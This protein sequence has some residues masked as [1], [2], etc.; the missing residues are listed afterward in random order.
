MLMCDWS[1]YVCS[2]DLLAD[3]S[4]YTPDKVRIF[5][6]QSEIHFRGWED[7]GARRIAELSNEIGPQC[8]VVVGTLEPDIRINTTDM[9][10][11]AICRI[12]YRGKIARNM[13]PHVKH[14]NLLVDV[15]RQCNRIFLCIIRLAIRK[16]IGLY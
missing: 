10:G 8:N 3:V 14:V 9:V 4:V 7:V 12:F 6:D 2:S 1:S 15:P 16:R 5:R 11:E 13:E